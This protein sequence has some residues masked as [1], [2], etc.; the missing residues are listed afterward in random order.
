MSPVT[1]NPGEFSFRPVV[2]KYITYFSA[3]RL[4][5]GTI[6]WQKQTILLFLS[7]NFYLEIIVQ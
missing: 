4:P 5:T 6:V 3:S 7:H 1:L 2:G